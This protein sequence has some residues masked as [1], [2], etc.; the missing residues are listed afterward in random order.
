MSLPWRKIWTSN[1]RAVSHSCNCYTTL[2][3]AGMLLTHPI[4]IMMKL[5]YLLNP[6]RKK[7]EETLTEKELLTELMF[8]LSR[9]PAGGATQAS[10]TLMLW[11]LY[12]QPAHRFTI[13]IFLLFNRPTFPSLP[14]QS[15]PL[16]SSPPFPI[17]SFLQ[18]TK[19][20]K[21]LRNGWM[22]WS[23]SQSGRRPPGSPDRVVASVATLLDLYPTNTNTKYAGNNWRK[24]HPSPCTAT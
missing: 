8:V 20:T 16:T 3:L 2:F 18:V 1:V 23:W 7:E 24:V 13:Y 5:I 17:V 21:C 6:Q 10:P 15:I 9:T 12:N 22:S 19:W 4:L 14:F 11:Q